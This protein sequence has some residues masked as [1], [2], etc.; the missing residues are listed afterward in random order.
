MFLIIIIPTWSIDDNFHKNRK[1]QVSVLNL[2]CCW[3]R[4]RA[5]NVKEILYCFLKQSL[6]L[7]DNCHLAEIS[8]TYVSDNRDFTSSNK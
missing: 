6:L 3:F 8:W 1:P 7:I 4:A 5:Q 2:K